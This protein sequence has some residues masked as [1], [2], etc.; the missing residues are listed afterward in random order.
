MSK[1]ELGEPVGAIWVKDF[2][3]RESICEFLNRLKPVCEHCH[4]LLSLEID[5]PGLQQAIRSHT[6]SVKVKPLKEKFIAIENT[7]KRTAT[8]PDYFLHVYQAYTGASPSY[9]FGTE[10]KKEVE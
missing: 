8:Q 10:R 4:Q 6:L 3:L 5:E 1:G 7:R 2:K 9:P